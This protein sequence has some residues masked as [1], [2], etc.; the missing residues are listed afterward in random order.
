MWLLL[1][2]EETGILSKGCWNFTVERMPGNSWILSIC[3][4]FLCLR[5]QGCTDGGN[6]WNCGSS[7]LAK[8]GPLSNSTYWNDNRLYWAWETRRPICFQVGTM[9]TNEQDLVH[10]GMFKDSGGDDIFRTVTSVRLRAPCRLEFMMAFT[11]G[12]TPMNSEVWRNNI[13]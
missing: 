13:W 8:S 1:K 11:V 6:L 3:V 5:I 10:R 4:H 2:P 9:S 12:H 7:P